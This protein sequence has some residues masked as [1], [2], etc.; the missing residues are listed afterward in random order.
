MNLLDKTKTA[1]DEL[2]GLERQRDKASKKLDEL[3][4]QIWKILGRPQGGSIT[5]PQ[6]SKPIWVWFGLGFLCG[7]ILVAL[8][9]LLI[10]LVVAL[11]GL[12]LW[13]KK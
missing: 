3:R 9:W 2:E 5:L 1:A 12:W 7:L 10:L 11:I 13:S 8:P 4:D 6:V